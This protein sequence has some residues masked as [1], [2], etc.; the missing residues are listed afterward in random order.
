MVVRSTRRETASGRASWPPR[1]ADHYDL[2]SHDTGGKRSGDAVDPRRNPSG[3]VQVRSS[4]PG[5]SEANLVRGRRSELGGVLHQHA[6]WPLQG[7]ADQRGG[8]ACDFRLTWLPAAENA[9]AEER[10][11]LCEMTIEVAGKKVS[12]FLDEDGRS[13]FLVLPAVHLAEGIASNWWTIFGGRDVRQR[14]APWRSGFALPNL[15]F[16]FNG[17][18]M[19]VVCHSSESENPRLAF[20]ASA[21]EYVARSEAEQH[22]AD[23]VTRVVDKLSADGVDNSEVSLAWDRV[24]ESRTSSDELV[25]CEAAGALGANPYSISEADAAFIESAGEQF[26]GEALIEFLA[27]FR[28]SPS[29]GDSRSRTIEWIGG[30]RNRPRRRSLLPELNDVV[31]GT[32]DVGDE[33]SGFAWTRGYR[34]AR[35]FREV[36]GFPDAG[37]HLSLREMATRLGGNSFERKRGPHSG[38]Y[39]I[40]ARD[41]DG[42]HVHLRDRGT[43]KWARTTERFAFARAVGDAVCFPESTFSPINNLHRAERQA[44]G[45]AFA[46]EFLAPIATV[47]EM[48]DGGLDVDEI[49]GHL[50]VNELVVQLQ[51]DNQEGLGRALGS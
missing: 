28:H 27:G 8:A 14:I 32:F 11:T 50:D 12:A 20:W 7:V 34:A 24:T 13:E 41:D 10:A 38:T 40:V 9:S 36:I 19:A 49:A 1:K 37:G 29:E 25:F 5:F 46:A 44:V 30:L 22:F 26:E 21:R 3:T 18:K 15:S 47:L 31:L 42:V 39:A 2:S 51:I 35:E 45:R 4:G 6:A 48:R 23:F 17:A 33:Q 43:A 16:E